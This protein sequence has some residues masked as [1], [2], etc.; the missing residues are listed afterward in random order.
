MKWCCK[1]LYL[2]ND[3]GMQQLTRLVLKW[4]QSYFAVSAEEKFISVFGT[5]VSG[6]L[7]A[8]LPEI[9]AF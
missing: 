7:N 3:S 6:Y 1:A 4:S 5:T 8:N 2:V 9:T